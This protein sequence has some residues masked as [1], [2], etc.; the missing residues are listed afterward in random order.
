MMPRYK[1]RICGREGEVDKERKFMS[2][3]ITLPLQPGFKITPRGP[4]M[5]MTTVGHSDC[6]FNKSVSEINLDKLDKLPDD[7]KFERERRGLI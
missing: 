1:C 5:A 2:V 3:E 4:P 7:H 6:E